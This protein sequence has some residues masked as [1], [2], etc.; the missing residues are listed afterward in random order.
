MI[1]EITELLTYAAQQK[2]SDLH[3][4]VGVQPVI[5]VHGQLIKTSYPVLEREAFHTMLNDIL[6]E[7]QRSRFD[8]DH[9]LDFSVDLEGVARFRV[10]A[11]VTRRGV[12][13]AFRLIAERIP[14]PQELHLPEQVLELCNLERGLVLVTG[15]TGSGKSTTLASLIDQTNQHRECHIITLEDPIE[16]VHKHNKSI[17]NQREVGNHT[18]S[19]AAALRSALREDPDVILVGEMR[20]LETIQLAIRAAETGHLV[21][22]TLHTASAGRTLDRIVDVFPSDQQEQI[23]VQVADIIEAV[24]AQTLVSTVDRMGQVPAME[25]MFASSAIRNLI[26]ENKAFQIPTTIQLSTQVGMQSMDQ[27]LVLLARQNLVTAA[28]A[29]QKALDRDNFKHLMLGKLPPAAGG[30]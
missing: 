8:A 18:H 17:I 27:A 12:A 14:S 29:E 25:V 28:D 2:A 23:R 1:M 10:N 11:Y 21:F 9:E 15:P 6:T 16:Y 24:L 3:L 26:R 22:S 5:R 7:D 20:D 4:T 30:R 19:F 13:A